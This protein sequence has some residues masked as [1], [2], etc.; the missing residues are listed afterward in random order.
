M[1]QELSGTYIG[2]FD[3]IA[4]RYKLGTPIDSDE[5]RRIFL[6][7]V[8]F[9]DPIIVNSKYIYSNELLTDDLSNENS[10]LRFAAEKGFLR[11]IS[12]RDD[13]V[14]EPEISQDDV[15]DYK[16]LVR[17][18]NWPQVRRKLERIQDA[19]F[20]AN[21]IFR[22]PKKHM[23]HA[24]Y[25]IVTKSAINAISKHDQMFVF[26]FE[27]TTLEDIKYFLDDIQNYIQRSNPVN[28]DGMRS[29]MQEIAQQVSIRR[30]GKTEKQ[31]NIEK[32]LINYVVESEHYSYSYLLSNEHDKTI[33][34][35]TSYSPSFD[36][37]KKN[38]NDI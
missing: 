14:R 21:L 2:L 19:A 34:S 1:V 15:P 6:H 29:R 35:L 37:M 33:R 18:S 30:Y 8:L 9:D 7:H 23:G 28:Y 3:D 10:F 36:E 24:L 27:H 17:S 5:I 20:N 31:R 22:W 26:G 25:N 4:L 11:I 16:K 12:R 38:I 32:E 13:F